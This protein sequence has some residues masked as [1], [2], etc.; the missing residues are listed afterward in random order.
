MDIYQTEDQKAEAI[1]KYLKENKKNIIFIII[2]FTCSFFG[3]RYYKHHKNIVIENASLEF[4]K[5]FQSDVD[6]DYT[7]VKMYANKLKKDHKKSPYADLATMKLAKLAFDNND[8]E[9]AKEHL[10]WVIKK[11]SKGPLFHVALLRLARIHRNEGK[12][13]EALKLLNKSPKGFASLYEEIKGDI[14]YDQ[15]KLS[16]ARESY[17]KALEFAPKSGTVPWL[18]LKLEDLAGI[19]NNLQLSQ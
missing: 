6:K 18:Q 2:L 3:M 14:F 12:Y 5:M 13:D 1:M 15:G 17:S 16:K 7:S 9:N 8:I 11:K 10:K 4:S 19:E